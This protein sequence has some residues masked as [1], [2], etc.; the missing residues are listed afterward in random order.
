MLMGAW[1][2]VSVPAFRTKAWRVRSGRCAVEVKRGCD[3]RLAAVAALD[4]RQV[5][6]R[7]E[8][9]LVRSAVAR[10]QRVSA[11]PSCEHQPAATRQ[12]SA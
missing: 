10:W 5:K 2:V 4:L 6:D 3:P 9:K 12:S 1:V 11:S 8:A 7:D